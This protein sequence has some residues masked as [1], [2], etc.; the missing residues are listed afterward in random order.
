[1]LTHVLCYYRTIVL[2]TINYW[3]KNANRTTKLTTKF[4]SSSSVNKKNIGL[5]TK[6]NK[7]LILKPN[8]TT[9]LTT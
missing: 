3:T 2:E 7:L 9:S 6:P 5:T 8:K 1:M 4:R